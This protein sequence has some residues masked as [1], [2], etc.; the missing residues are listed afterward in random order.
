MSDEIRLDTFTAKDLC[1]LVC[2]LSKGFWQ[3]DW[4]TKK[5][6]IAWLVFV[7]S[8]FGPGIVTAPIYNRIKP[9]LG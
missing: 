7:V 8:V 2:I 6:F 3:M 9:L 5:V 1:R 4:Q